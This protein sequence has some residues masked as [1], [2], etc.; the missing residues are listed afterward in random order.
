MPFLRADL[1]VASPSSSSLIYELRSSKNLIGSSVAKCDVVVPQTLDLHALLS[2]SPDKASGSL[3]PFSAS[4]EGTC[5]LNNRTV[6]LEGARVV[7]GDRLAFGTVEN[8]F[9]FE[10]TSQNV[11]SSSS[12]SSSRPSPAR[13][14]ITGNSAATFRKALDALR[15]DRSVT[16]F[17]ASQAKSNGAKASNKVDGTSRRPSSSSVLSSTKGGQLSKFLL[18]ASSDS[19]LSEYVERK[20]RQSAAASRRQRRAPPMAMEPP[21]SLSSST[22][23]S[24]RSSL[25]DS[26][27][28]R[29]TTANTE[30]AAQRNSMMTP[31]VTSRSSN[32]STVERN[33]AE[34]EKLRL[35]Q[36]LREVNSV[37]NGEASFSASYLSSRASRSL[38]GT[39]EKQHHNIDE[40][41]SLGDVSDEEVD[42]DEEEDEL[43]AM[44]EKPTP[45]PRTAAPSVLPNLIPEDAQDD[46]DAEEST[47]YLNDSL[48]GF[49]EPIRVAQKA[50][51]PRLASIVA[52]SLHD[53]A[54]K[55]EAA[56][57]VVS[58]SK[59]LHRQRTAL[60]QQLIDQTLRHK[61]QEI[62]GH[63]FVRWRRG[64][65]I[66]HQHRQQRAQQLRN[67][68]QKLARVRRNHIFFRWKSWAGMA[69]QVASCR[70]D[71]FQQRCD[72][73]RVMRVWT[74]WRIQHLIARQRQYLLRSIFRRRFA[75]SIGT[76][77]HTWTRRTKHLVG[78]EKWEH[79]QQQH[80]QNWDMR[81]T[82]VAESHHSRHHFNPL[83]TRILRS[84]HAIAEV[85]R[86]KL[87]ALKT[88]ALRG[89][90]KAK[91]MAWRKWVE[92]IT[93]SRHTAA[94]EHEQHTRAQKLL[95]EQQNKHQQIHSALQNQHAQEL[96]R[97]HNQFQ[98][99][100][101]ELQRAESKQQQQATELQKLQGQL[102]NKE[103]QKVVGSTNAWNQSVE[104]Y[105]ENA[106]KQ[107]CSMK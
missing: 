102:Q 61:R 105:F 12:L 24:M 9:V 98:G 40:R 46:Q 93:L 16:S 57:P 99:K 27:L 92:L 17:R 71:A 72:H 14:A 83:L 89:S 104:S 41:A 20:L 100:E 50:E 75:K 47:D 35:A 52:R 94:V 6:P 8:G 2:V 18:D 51:Q 77:F 65:R 55:S 78:Q 21:P 63:A 3:V 66:Q 70:M 4:G 95:A 34:M 11:S 45:A 68:K 85:Q 49:S 42:D 62:V 53:S 76:A 25:E 74:Q 106:V 84:W 91:G 1:G 15:G 90:S 101:H 64:F 67:L 29:M 26:I 97:L 58:V 7:H 36:Q 23:S 73:R 56:S 13:A 60:H 96:Q 10:L 59:T 43:P 19:Q 30:D 82:K 81:M 5:Y 103:R 54:S 33:Y 69:S 31:S 86:K 38:R 44:M 80:Q 39:D 37:L 48:P 87:Q 28:N 88:I 79:A 107:T 32:L 22:V